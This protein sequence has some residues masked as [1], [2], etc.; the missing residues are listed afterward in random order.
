MP[1][2]RNRKGAITILMAI[3]FV[4]LIAMMGAAVDMSRLFM[5]RN[6]LQTAADAAAMAGAIQLLH[7]PANAAAQVRE[8]AITNT[9]LDAGVQ[10][11]PDAD[12]EYGL[13]KDSLHTFDAATLTTADAVRVKLRAP[14][15]YLF[16]GVL[17][18][19]AVE[20]SASATG[21]A[22]APVGVLTECVKPFALPYEVLMNRL[23]SNDLHRDLTEEDMLR[24][25]QMTVQQR[26]FSLKFGSGTESTGLPGNYYPVVLG[27]MWRKSLNGGQGAYV[28]PAPPRGAGNVT[29]DR[30]TGNIAN[31]HNTPLQKG[32]SLWTEAG[33]KVGPTIKG[34]EELCEPLDNDGN[35]Y[36]AEGEIG[37]PIKAA[38]WQ[39]NQPVNGRSAVEVRIL[40]SFVLTN[41]AP[42]DIKQGSVIIREKGSVT[43]YFEA[44][45]DAGQVTSNQ[46]LVFRPILVR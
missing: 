39:T 37:I 31:C 10:S 15:S 8:Y 1:R 9:V 11:P 45:D 29:D 43:G 33:N 17:G 22:R 19:S 14:S 44:S 4:V 18:A 23:G 34:A 36:N 46:S 21:W 30:Y 40:G 3:M 26:T 20:V 42:R 16:M 6:Q 24:L 27:A 13:W 25:R 28:S 35:C 12:I 2:L 32:D 38:F 5:M 7:N 41:V